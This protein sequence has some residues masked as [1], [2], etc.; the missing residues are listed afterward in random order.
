VVVE[1]E[2]AQGEL[3]EPEVPEGAGML[4]LVVATTR[5]YRELQI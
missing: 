2:Q 5:V 3:L 1:V 4:V